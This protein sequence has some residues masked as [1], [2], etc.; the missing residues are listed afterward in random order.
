MI[1]AEAHRADADLERE[2]FAWLI[3]SVANIAG[4]KPRVTVDRLL[5]RRPDERGEREHLKQNE[6]AVGLLSAIARTRAPPTEPK[7]QAAARV[8]PNDLEQMQARAAA[9]RGEVVARARPGDAPV[10]PAQ[11]QANLEAFRARMRGVQKRAAERKATDDGG[12]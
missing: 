10:A 7:P 8:S 2:N 11:A 3:A 6:V 4:A 9:T 5:R 12:S 1:Y